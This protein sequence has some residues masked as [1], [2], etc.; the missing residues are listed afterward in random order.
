[1]A[2][3][4]LSPSPTGQCKS[5]LLIPALPTSIGHSMVYL[6]FLL[7]CFLGTAIIADI[8]MCAIER[9]TSTTKK[10]KKKRE[11]LPLVEQ[12]KGKAVQ[13][14]EEEEYEYVKV[15]NPTVAN[16]T[17]M[18]LGSSAPEIL[19]SLIEIVGNDFK[20]G[21]LGP[22][23]IVGSAAFNLFCI[24]AICVVSV[25]S[26]MSKRIEQISV[27]YITAAFSVFAYVWI[28]FILV[29][30]SPNIIDIWEAALTLFFFFVLV[31]V[32]Y[33]FDVQLWKKRATKATHGHQVEVAIDSGRQKE[34]DESEEGNGYHTSLTADL[35]VP[36][37][38]TV[39]N[40]TREVARVYPSLSPEDHA[41]ILAYRI[42]QATT[43]HDRM[44]YRIK[45][46]RQMTS[47]WRESK[48]EQEVKKFLAT[49][50][51]ISPDGRMKP[52]IEW[53]ARAYGVREGDK[54]IQLTIARR[55]PVS[56]PITV[57]YHTAN[58]TAKKDQHFMDKKESIQFDIGQRFKVI[59][60]LLVEDADWKADSL[61]YVHLKIQDQ[62]DDD[63]TKL[64]ECNVARVRFVEP[65]SGASHPTAEFAK[66]N[67]VISESKGWVRV[68][69]K[70]RNRPATTDKCIV[71]Y[72]TEDV[73]AQAEQDYVGVKEG[74]VVFEPEEIEKYIDIEIIDDKQDEKDETFLVTVVRVDEQD[75][76]ITS[77]LR[78]TVTII[79][80]DNALKNVTN[81]R[82]LM[83][84]YLKDMKLERA[85]WTEQIINASSVNGGDIVNA[86]FCDAIK[87]GLAFPWK[88]I[89]AFV[90]PPELLGGWPCFFVAL[91]LIGVV[92][93]IIGD[94]ASIFG[95]MVGI[96]DAI[97]A[98]TFVALGTSL[99]DTFA[100]KIAAEQDRAAD[101]AVGN[102]TGSN[103]VNVFLG[104]GLPWLV[105]AIYW[106]AKGEKFVVNAGDLTYSV[107]LFTVLS[108]VCLFVLSTRRLLPSCGNGELGGPR[109]TKI[110]TA[111]VF[112]ALWIAYIVLS[113][114]RT[115]SH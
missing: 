91:A 100:S 69:L 62:E 37:L 57:A 30:S 109:G 45:A 5:G 40:M 36:D 53:S 9:I 10:I 2:D 47:S 38:A 94:L 101:N 25:A 84:N 13:V 90:P 108:L 50:K 51:T 6:F 31:I 97:T 106:A 12:G 11:E 4:P 87:H 81:V 28:L 58:G 27:F 85:S 66:Q 80:D 98:I 60:L 93:A 49:T 74:R 8:F 61:F 29:V 63:R 43:P 83:R 76:P 7:Y 104:L 110:V 89:F 88:F 17:L 33:A 34:V 114:R 35:P 48:T 113:I 64:G 55:G 46:I 32:A 99:P 67:Y 65:S 107:S 75:V 16:L 95:C 42:N 70:L 22:G 3:P 68:F 103:S 111:I 15:W 14:A 24:S 54:R 73:S 71:R 44:Y 96:G 112:V 39:R 77:K 59:D 21:D 86:T 1:M 52:R 102:I 82:K 23:T 72:S 79:S 56:Y 78:A 92:T 20:A 19:L 115:T 26:P 41:K 18:A 105:A